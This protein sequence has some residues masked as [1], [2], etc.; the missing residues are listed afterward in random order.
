MLPKRPDL[1]GVRGKKGIYV[2]CKLF[3]LSHWKNGDALRKFCFFNTE[4][5]RKVAEEVVSRNVYRELWR[6]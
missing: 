6:W 4:R 1:E 5:L 2:N 3:S